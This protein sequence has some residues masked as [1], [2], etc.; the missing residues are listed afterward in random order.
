MTGPDSIECWSTGIWTVHDIKDKA[1]E[2]LAELGESFRGEAPSSLS[3]ADLA[4]A[5]RLGATVVYDDMRYILDP[6]AENPEYPTRINHRL[7]VPKFAFIGMPMFPDEKRTDDANDLYFVLCHRVTNLPPQWA[8]T[9]PGYAYMACI[10]V[11]WK[12][13]GRLNWLYY[14]TVD[15][16][17]GAIYPCRSFSAHS[18]RVGPSCRSRGRYISQP[19][20]EIDKYWRTQ[21]VKDRHGKSLSFG[22]LVCLALNYAPHIDTHWRFDMTRHAAKFQRY[23]LR[24]SL[25]LN[26]EIVTKVFRG[27]DKVEHVMTRGGRRRPILHWTRAHYRKRYAKPRNRWVAL[28]WKLLPFLRPVVGVSTVKTHLRGLRTF[29]LDG[30]DCEIR[31]P[32]LHSATLA[33]SDLTGVTDGARGTIGDWIDMD[34]DAA[35]EASLLPEGS[36]R[37]KP[38]WYGAPP[39]QRVA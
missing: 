39:A 6:T 13:H 12:K 30:Y 19:R 3:D 5:K 14:F 18:S 1:Q 25:V 16:R 9:G 27:R 24:V 26:P 23:P 15:E 11:R 2:A 35:I 33:S 17:D 8:P 20:W 28:L 37:Q 29:V 7:T 38:K 22:Q 34:G 31:L 10:W 21:P 32:G 36:V 4:M